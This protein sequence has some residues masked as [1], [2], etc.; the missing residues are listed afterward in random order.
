MNIALACLLL[1]LAQHGFEALLLLIQR[2][3]QARLSDAMPARLCQ[4]PELR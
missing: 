3:H 1:V 4:G 2:H